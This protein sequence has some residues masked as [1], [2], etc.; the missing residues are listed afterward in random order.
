M[1]WVIFLGIATGMRSMTAIA[2]VCCAAYIGWLPVENT[3]AAWCAKLVSVMIFAVL[4]LGEYVG[5]TLPK[6]PKRTDLGPLAA[7]CVFAM[8]AGVICATALGQPKAGGVILGLIGALIGAYAGMAVRLRL[9]KQCGRD[10]PV[11]LV[12][13]ALAL[14]ICALA[15]V[16]IHHEVM[17]QSR[18]LL[19]LQQSM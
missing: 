17:A 6:T 11:A 13:S 2:A 19:H 12:E 16:R 4:A 10:L 14:A 7:R 1:F 15:L 3:W 8:L 5:D 9:A 18:H